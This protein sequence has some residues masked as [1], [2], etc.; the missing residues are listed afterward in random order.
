M[1]DELKPRDKITQK[2]TRD[3]AI[4]E[5]QTTGETERIS[6]RIRDAD[7]QKTPEQQ[8]AQDAMQ[9]PPVSDTSPLPHA[10]GAAPKADT[11][12]AE[13][14]ME[15]LDAA[16]TRK[17]SKKAVR[18]AQE[19]AAAQ[20][21]SSRLQFTDEELATPELEKYIKKS[22]KAAD[23]LDK[24]KSA[25]PKQKK[26]VKER[27]FDEATGK[28]KTRLHF[29]EQDKPPGFKEKHNPLSRPAQEAGIFVHNKIH[30]VEKDNSGVEGAHKTEEA[31][32]R[33]V[34]YGARKFK[35][36]Y[37]SH[38]LK[39][40]REAAKAEKA[41][42]KANVDFQYHKTLHDNPQLTS[43]PL[44]RF[45]QK[46]QIKRQYAKAAKQGGAKGI[47]AAAENTRKAAKKAAE[48]TKQTAAFVARH[49]AGV[50]IAVGA[51]LLFILIMSGLSSCGAMFSGTLNGVLGTSYTSED[52]DLVEVENAYAG[53]E[54]ELQ[55][56]IDNIERTHSG[57]DEYRYDLANIGHNPHE[58]ASYLTAKYQSYTRADVQAELQRI[59]EQQYKL[60]LTEEVEVRYRTE[61][62]TDSYTVTDP[63]T[64][65]T[66]T[67]TYEYEVEVPYNYYILH[68]DLENFNLSHVPVY[69]M[70]EEQLSMYAMYMSSLGN[71]PDLFPSSGYVS[72]YYE[73]PPADYEVPAAL[74]GSDEKFAR[75]MEEADKYVGFPY[76]WGG[77]TP[78]TSF[79]CSG[80]VSYVLTNSGLYNTGRLGAQGLYNI[81]TRVSNPQPGDLVFFTGT[82]DTPGVSHVGIYVGEDGDG[83]PVML[84]CGDPIQYAKLDTSYWQS[85]FYAYGRLHYN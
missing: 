30:S 5:N 60:T 39:P 31:A 8:A 58:L 27:T 54:S 44:S 64:G 24:A 12:K 4:A 77:S 73:T 9:L 50:A 74:L 47:K 16:H 23:R 40:Y 71:R 57:Y 37:R 63:E 19:E 69:I 45:W 65:E 1:K 6:N 55:R 18:R 79:D 20:T 34:K 76:V 17:A 29:E 22:D 15:R 51:L 85:H 62:R 3:G 2:M 81:S 53:L 7:L 66:T 32:E 43:N 42:F 56:E 33:G 35:Q 41:A 84:H 38:K 59:F 72:K 48:K 25:I 10:P 80:F 21:K 36:G 26:L 61:T 49:P 11:G 78:E 82:Y 28:G 13:R 68:V 75:L 70:G 14:V 67:E 83:S 52:S 46:Q